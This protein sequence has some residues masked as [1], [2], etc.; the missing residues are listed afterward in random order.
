[1]TNFVCVLL[2]KALLSYCRYQRSSRCEKM[3]YEQ[4]FVKYLQS[5]L[6]EVDR[7]IK[8][9]LARLAMNA[10]AAVNLLCFSVT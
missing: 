7:R 5:I 10:A 8:R 2:I 1:M 3:G 9:G 4:D 6:T